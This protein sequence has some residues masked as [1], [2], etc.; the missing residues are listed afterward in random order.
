MDV[1]DHTA[2]DDVDPFS[3][4]EWRDDD[5]AFADFAL[6]DAAVDPFYCMHDDDSVNGSRGGGGGGGGGGDGDAL[7]EFFLACTGTS[8]GK[9]VSGSGRDGGVSGSGGAFTLDDAELAAI[10]HT[11][12]LEDMPLFT[13][14][15]AAAAAAAA[16]AGAGSGAGSA[17]VP[18]LKRE[19]TGVGLGGFDL[20][21][22][23][24]A[25]KVDSLLL[26]MGTSK[27]EEVQTSRTAAAAAACTSVVAAAAA[28]VRK[29]GAWPSAP[30]KRK[31]NSSQAVS[32]IS[33]DSDWATAFFG[34]GGS[35][36]TVAAAAVLASPSLPCALAKIKGASSKELS[37]SSDH[38]LA[39]RSNK[40]PGKDKEEQ[41]AP[42]PHTWL[43]SNLERVGTMFS[44]VGFNVSRRRDSD[45]VDVSCDDMCR[46]RGPGYE[47]FVFTALHICKSPVTPTVS[48]PWVPCNSAHCVR[49]VCVGAVSRD[50]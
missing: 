17:S 19:V 40:P 27:D 39:P 38:K 35:T 14:A 22:A 46:E 2:F 28:V 42:H 13:A 34:G 6:G 5:G 49:R 41:H 32:M 47:Y 37:S 45:R 21:A 29:R 24:A 44:C 25:A 8:E 33:S 1:R 11:L 43:V 48:P 7:G 18:T 31:K 15:A 12:L 9:R 3:W 50:M 20:S 23:L 10:A 26:S 30:K 4:I 36:A 16:L